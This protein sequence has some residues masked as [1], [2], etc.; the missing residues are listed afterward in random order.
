MDGVFNIGVHALVVLNHKREYV[1]S[2]SLAK[3]IC[4]N[5]AR[6][7]KVMSNLKKAGLVAT[8]E[9]SLG[10]YIINEDAKL[11]SL[12]R[13]AAALN[14]KFVDVSWKSGAVDMECLIASGMAGVMEDIYSSLDNKCFQSLKN[15]TIDD[16]DKKIFKKR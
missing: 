5:P 2:E 4:T 13:V 8:K 7:R 3:N 1:S 9:G 11:I 10:G 12:D 15:V 16:I 14:V 6:I